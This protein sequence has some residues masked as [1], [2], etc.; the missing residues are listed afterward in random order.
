MKRILLATL[1]LL[2]AGMTVYAQQAAQGGTNLPS[3]SQ[4][5][6]NAQQYLTQAKT[7]G[8][9]FTSALSDLNARNLSNK[10]LITFNQLK[11]EIDR[12]EA[13]INTEQARIGGNLDSGHKVDAEL[14]NRIQR[15]IDQHK[16]KMDELEAFISG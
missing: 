12:L 9:Q 6:Q 2:L 8:S 13:L 16:A 4:T 1:I 10:D 5:K 14:L 15:L 3:S 11:T 7:N